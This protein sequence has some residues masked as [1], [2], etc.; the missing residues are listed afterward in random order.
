MDSIQRP[1]PVSCVAKGAR[2]MASAQV[3]ESI[4]E[5]GSLV[6]E[7]EWGDEVEPLWF[8]SGFRLGMRTLPHSTATFTWTA[9]V[10]RPRLVLLRRWWGIPWGQ[11]LRYPLRV[12]VGS[13]V[14]CDPPNYQKEYPS[15]TCFGS[16]VV[17]HP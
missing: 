3:A 14:V 16:A 4:P 12:D 5:P 17:L 2:V 13:A 8:G 11:C 7:C 15:V 6:D 9:V 1:E 10:R